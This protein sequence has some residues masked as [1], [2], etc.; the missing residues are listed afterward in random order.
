MVWKKPRWCNLLIKKYYTSSYPG[1]KEKTK[2]TC[3][4][5]K[6]STNNAYLTKRK[7]TPKEL[8]KQT[9]N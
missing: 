7:K 4:T 1:K 8:L 2:N 3:A 6:S 9:S 5:E